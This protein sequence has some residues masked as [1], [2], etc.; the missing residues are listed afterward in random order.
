MGVQCEKFDAAVE[1]IITGAESAQDHA[2]GTFDLN[3]ALLKE[4][5]VQLSII[6]QAAKTLRRWRGYSG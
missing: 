5:E 6:Y 3:F 4:V 1:R 2:G